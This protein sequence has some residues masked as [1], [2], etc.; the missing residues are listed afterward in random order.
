MKAEMKVKYLGLEKFRGR[1]DPDKVFVS[2]VFLQET[3]TIK[4]FLKD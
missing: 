4:V 2:A 1:K 3:E